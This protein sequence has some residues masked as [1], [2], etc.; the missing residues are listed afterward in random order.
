MTDEEVKTPDIEILR[1]AADQLIKSIEKANRES[2]ELYR[3][4]IETLVK[5]DFINITLQLGEFHISFI[6]K[7]DGVQSFGAILLQSLEKFIEAEIPYA[8]VKNGNDPAYG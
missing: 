2:R 7:R 6:G 1:K 5:A 3:E 4:H 8:S